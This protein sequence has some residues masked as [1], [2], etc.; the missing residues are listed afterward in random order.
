MIWMMFYGLNN[1]YFDFKWYDIIDISLV[2][3]KNGFMCEEILDN[4]VIYEE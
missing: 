1:R 3:I 4:D 2:Q